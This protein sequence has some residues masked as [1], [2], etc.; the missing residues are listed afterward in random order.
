MPTLLLS[1][2]AF[3]RHDTGP[4]HPE[5]VERLRAITETL[6]T[7]S[8]APL[9]RAEAQPVDRETIARV[10]PHAHIDRILGLVPETGYSWVD[11]DTVLS[12]ASGEAALLSV[13]A[14]VEAV[15][16]VMAGKVRNAFC[17][18]RPPGHHAETDRAMGFCFFNNVAIAAFHARAAHGIKR[19]ACIDFDVHHGN[20]TQDIFENDPD[21]LYISTHQAGAY[22]H[23]G[24]RYETGVANNIVNIPLPAG[25][26]SAE[27]R[28]AISREAIPALTAFSPELILISA[29]FDAHVA[30]PLAHL[31]LKT[32]DFG[33]VTRQIDKIAAEMCGGRIVS[34]LEGGYNIPALA[35]SVAAHVRALMGLED[36]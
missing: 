24:H 19:I 7:E 34:A 23:T 28:T 36:R 26:G 12:P 32:E 29:G 21:L 6:A 30:D 2:A 15:D 27:F 14:V 18:V 10:H 11:P 4:G 31:R 35:A 3:L 20:G 5:S 9:I 22:P 17:A 8:F 25:A 1:H 13:G 33:W 16:E